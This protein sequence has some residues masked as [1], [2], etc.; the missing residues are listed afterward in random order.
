MGSRPQK[1][2]A[3]L[4][5]GALST[6]D[7]RD[8]CFDKVAS[9]FGGPHTGG[10][11]AV[12]AGQACPRVPLRA[13]F[14][15]CEGGTMAGKLRSPHAADTASSRGVVR[16]S[17][18][19]R[20]LC[21]CAGPPGQRRTGNRL[22]APVPRG[23]LRVGNAMHDPNS[24]PT[25]P[26]SSERSPL[27]ML[28][29]GARP[30]FVKVAPVQR[31]LARRGRL[32]TSLVHTGQHHDPEM[33]EV[34]FRELGLPEPD[35]HLGIAGGSHAELTA[36]VMM[37]LDRTI[38]ALRPDLVL[39]VGDVDSTLAAALVASKR[40]VPLAHVEAGLRSRDRTMPEEINRV[41]TDRISDLLFVTE[42]DA[43]D[44]LVAEG[45]ARERIDLV[46]N[47]MIDTL[48]A[49]RERVEGRAPPRAARDLLE[50]DFA[51]ATLHRPAN[52]DDR[53]R[54]REILVALD[55]VAERI[56]I[57]LPLHPRTRR[58]IERFG[59]GERIGDGGPL[60]LTEPM[61]YLDFLHLML[62]AKLVLTDSGGIQ[63][64]TTAIGTPCLTMRENTERP[65]TI[66]QGT[67]RLVGG[68]R[69]KIVEAA[70]E[71][72]AAPRTD[73]SA[74]PLWDGRAAERIADA[75]ERYLRGP[76]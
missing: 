59:W 37:A 39:V 6:S 49:C 48:F 31:A 10:R 20:D 28:V 12:I 70:L 73:L 15:P 7:R 36:R 55:E 60:R 30:N 74:P 52:V 17:P 13:K 42:A 25:T 63:E 44:N 47:V 19:P 64:E 8:R 62:R 61:G 18:H 32:R 43:V 45:V 4:R 33:S 41:L 58:S 2:K 40:G 22:S 56:P 54:L 72:L 51:L 16:T 34:F 66:N 27:V 67:N 9:L 5:V 75:I 3:S 76:E 68:S 71:A 69:P 53:E 50:S 26:R 14:P 29:A 35:A 1:S 21:A 11:V 23:S 38:E 46:G 24:A 65:I 57:V